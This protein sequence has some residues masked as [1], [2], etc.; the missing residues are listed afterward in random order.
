MLFTFLKKQKEKSHKVE[1]VK[2]LI[3]ELNIS[4]E[5]KELYVKALDILEVHELDKLYSEITVFTQNFELKEVDDI[6]KD[7]FVT[8]AGMKKR[9]VEEKKQE[10]NAFSFLINNI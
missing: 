8:V 2:T 10:V 9:E 4:E 6:K 5:Q 1:V 3:L 7:S